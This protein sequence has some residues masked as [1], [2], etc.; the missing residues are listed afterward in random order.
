MVYKNGKMADQAESSHCVL[1]YIDD[2]LH[3]KIQGRSDNR[4]T[5][6]GSAFTCGGIIAIF[7]VY[8]QLGT[9]QCSSKRVYYSCST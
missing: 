9:G 6:G 2:D 7:Y 5:L 4:G 8:E 1:R 3:F